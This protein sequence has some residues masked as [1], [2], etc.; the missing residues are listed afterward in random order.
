MA[1]FI[2]DVLFG[3][4]PYSNESDPRSFAE[5]LSKRIQT[6]CETS[7]YRAN[8]QTFEICRGVSLDKNNYVIRI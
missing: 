5:E 2:E 6:S 8:L 3:L 1:A 7:V 4:Q